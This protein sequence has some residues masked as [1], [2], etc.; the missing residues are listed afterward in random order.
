[1]EKAIGISHPIPKRRQDLNATNG[2]DGWMAR[3]KKR[4]TRIA[5]PEKRNK[6]YVQNKRDNGKGC[7]THSAASRSLFS[8]SL[9]PRLALCSSGLGS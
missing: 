2:M 4:K 5:S 7:Y 9:S 3:R 6:N 8:R 1:M